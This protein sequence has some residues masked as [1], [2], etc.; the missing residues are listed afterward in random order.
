MEHLAGLLD[1]DF[2]SGAG[3]FFV[4][5]DGVAFV[6]EVAADLVGAAG[7]DAEFEVGGLAVAV[8]NFDEGGGDVALDVGA[9]F[10]PDVG[11]FSD[12][13]GAVDFDDV[14]SAEEGYG[15]GFGFG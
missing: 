15:V 11:E 6:G 12:G 5:E 1:G 13:E 4:A 7:F 9:D 14:A 3:I 2:V 8:E 10:V